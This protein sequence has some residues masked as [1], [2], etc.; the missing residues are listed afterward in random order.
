MSADIEQIANDMRDMKHKLD[1]LLSDIA[2][3]K[4]GREAQDLKVDMVHGRLNDVETRLRAAEAHADNARRI[5][6]LERRQDQLG[7][8]MEN[9][10][11]QLHARISAVSNAA[12]DVAEVKELRAKMQAI[13]L[14]FARMLGLLAG[15]AA[16]GGTA[17]ALV[18]SILSVL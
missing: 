1:K 6:E 8:K 5:T 4:G 12:A 16:V 2:T 7:A 18:K 11:E 14:T 9:T 3:I 10:S 17:G 13:E 15:A